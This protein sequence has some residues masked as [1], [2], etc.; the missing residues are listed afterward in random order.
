MLFIPFFIIKIP[1]FS[2]I[3]FS[4]LSQSGAEA[5]YWMQK[6]RRD[7]KSLCGLSIPSIVKEGKIRIDARPD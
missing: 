5:H 2:E 1:P 3:E 7:P 6:N 4:S